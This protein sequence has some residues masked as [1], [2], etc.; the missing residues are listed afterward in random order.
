MAP[1]RPLAWEPPYAQGV[2]LKRQ[3]KKSYFFRGTQ[4]L[5]WLVGLCPYSIKN[6]VRVCSILIKVSRLLL[7]LVKFVFFH[8][9]FAYIMSQFIQMY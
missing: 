8:C 5:S 2:A 7:V 3:K 9:Y 6:E 4:G 1:L